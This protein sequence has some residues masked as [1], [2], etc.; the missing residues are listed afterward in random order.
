MNYHVEVKVVRAYD[1]GVPQNKE[2]IYIVG[3]DKD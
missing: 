2:R 3:F 1:Y